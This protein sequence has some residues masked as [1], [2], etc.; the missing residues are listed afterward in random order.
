[1]HGKI[2]IYLNQFQFVFLSLV[3]TG[4]LIDKY[5]VFFVHA[6]KLLIIFLLNRLKQKEISFSHPYK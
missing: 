5:V 6:H 4:F 3:K 2:I 1:M